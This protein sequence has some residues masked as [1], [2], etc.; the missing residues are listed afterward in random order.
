MLGWA[1][2]AQ[3]TQETLFK[4]PWSL[5]HLLLHWAISE[6]THI[7]EFIPEVLADAGLG[8]RAQWR[9]FFYSYG[10]LLVVTA[11]IFLGLVDKVA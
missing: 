2:G 11:L 7:S 5:G 9:A 8:S 1:Q 10:L 3:E 4:S 6:N